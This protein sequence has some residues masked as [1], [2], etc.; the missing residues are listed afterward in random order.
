M[1][2]PKCKKLYGLLLFQNKYTQFFIRKWQKSILMPYFL[3]HFHNDF[4]CLSIFLTHIFKPK[5]KKMAIFLI[6]LN[7][8]LRHQINLYIVHISQTLLL[9]R[10]LNSVD[11]DEYCKASFNIFFFC[12][13]LVYF[14][15]SV[16]FSSVTVQCHKVKYILYTLFLYSGEHKYFI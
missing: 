6:F 9:K 14:L 11:R 10:S 4:L 15:K 7:R 8:Q 3:N 1:L 16:I 5:A 2:A 12:C 13:Q